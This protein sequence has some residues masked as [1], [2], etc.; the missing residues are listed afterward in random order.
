MIEQFFQALLPNFEHSH[1]LAYWVAFVV[2]F[3]ETTLVVGLLVP[4][5]TL[6]LLLGDGGAVL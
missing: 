3:V 5:S 6:L 2:A 4:G 1:S